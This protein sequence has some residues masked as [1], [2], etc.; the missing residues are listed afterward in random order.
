MDDPE[1][2]RIHAR[3]CQYLWQCKYC[4]IE[5]K[6]EYMVRRHHCRETESESEDELVEVKQEALQDSER[7]PSS[8]SPPA[9]AVGGDGDSSLIRTANKKQVNVNI[10][11]LKKAHIDLMVG[12][13]KEEDKKPT[14]EEISLQEVRR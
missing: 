8:P 11:P 2:L 14:K 7:D 9:P 12:T 3:N 1:D 5:Y 6:K 10:T 4:K 13:T